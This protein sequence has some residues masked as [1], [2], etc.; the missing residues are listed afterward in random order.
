MTPGVA[1]MAIDIDRVRSRFPSLDTEWVFL[2]NGGGSQIAQPV[3]D[4]INEYLLTSNVQHGASYEVS[5]LAGRRLRDAQQ[6]MATLINARHPSEVV[7]GGSTTLLLQTLATSFAKRLGPGDEVIVSSGDHEANICPWLEL[8]R[9]GVE[10]RFWDVD[11]GSYELRL[12]DLE[13]LLGPRTRLV[14]VTHSSNILGTI[15]PVRKIAD[16]VHAAGALLCVDGVAYAP[17]RAID[18]QALDID[19]YAFSFYKTYGPHYALLYGKR[20]LLLDLPSRSFFFIPEDDVPYKFQPGGVNYEL[21][22][23]MLGV[24]DYLE[25]LASAGRA[26]DRDGD[27]HQRDAVESSFAM[28]AKYED[29]LSARLLGFLRGRPGVRVIGREVADR[30]VRVPTVSFIVD[31]MLS[32]AVV[33]QVDRHRI[34]I[35]YGDFYS[36]RLIEQLG[37]APKDGVVRV[38]MVHYNTLEE[39]DRLISVLDAILPR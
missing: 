14:A 22:Y 3:L 13:S 28:I 32:S 30:A 24:M 12:E 16:T 26:T 2:D 18:V 11:P 8:E 21:S 25:E 4:R 6:A 38:S 15:N 20:E 34:G 17:H 31:G 10:V 7:M 35:R 36:V 29:A 39:I 9:V 23:G 37:L 33:R 27:G 5:E 19:F 1:P